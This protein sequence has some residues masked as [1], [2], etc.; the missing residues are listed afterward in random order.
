MCYY[1]K[2]S[3]SNYVFAIDHKSFNIYFPRLMY[4]SSVYLCEYSSS[5][6]IEGLFINIPVLKL[7]IQP[8]Y[9]YISCKNKGGP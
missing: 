7:A 3:E 8:V 1:T 5:E 2:S 9:Y 4:M 6:I